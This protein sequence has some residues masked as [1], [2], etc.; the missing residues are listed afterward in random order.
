MK[1]ALLTKCVFGEAEVHQDSPHKMMELKLDAFSINP[2]ENNILLS[3]TLFFADEKRQAQNC[4]G[5]W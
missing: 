1:L 3:R 5:E 4:K 2:G